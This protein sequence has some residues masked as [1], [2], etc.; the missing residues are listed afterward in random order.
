[1]TIEVAG[2]GNRQQTSSWLAKTLQRG[3][4]DE[5]EEKERALRVLSL[6]HIPA[7]K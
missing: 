1:M 2:V 5:R 4:G 7:E 6:K 3:G